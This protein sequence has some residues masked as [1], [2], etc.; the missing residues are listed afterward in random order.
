[1]TAAEIWFLRAEAALRGYISGDPG[2]YYKKGVETSF[3]QWG[4]DNVSD[5]L[6]SEKVPADYKD[7]FDAKFDVAAVS[8]VTPKW[9]NALSN[10]QKL[11]KIIT[12]KWLAIYPEGCEAWTEQRRTGYP[13]LFKVAVN[14]SGGTIDTDIMIRRLF[15][16]QALIS[17]NP[18]QYEQL[19]QLLGGPDTGGTRLWWDMGRNF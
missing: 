12:Q 10:E 7:A 11:E 14:N 4:A 8:K 5:Y 9:D 1:M 17:D 16:P 2:E 15:Y 3:A 19:L 18:T 13:K 6:A